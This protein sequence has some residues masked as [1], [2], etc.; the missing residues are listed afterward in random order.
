MRYEPVGHQPSFSMS[1]GWGGGGRFLGKMF[2]KNVLAFFFSKKL[3]LLSCWS[4]WEIFYF[5]LVELKFL[6]LHYTN[7]I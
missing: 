1:R 5:L 4:L 2:W 6:Q 7:K 3:N